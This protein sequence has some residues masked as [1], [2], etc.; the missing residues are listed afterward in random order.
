MPFDKDYVRLVLNENFEDAKALFLTPLMAI[1][2]AHLAM[3]AEQ[4]I[5][6]IEAARA[7]RGALA[8]IDLTAVRPT[9]YDGAYEDLVFY[10]ERLERD[11]TRLAAAFACV[12]RNPLGACA[13]TGTGFPIDRQRTSDLLGFDGPTGN[14]YGSIAAADYLLESVAAANVLL[15]GLGRL[16]QDL[17]LWCTREFG[18]LRLPDSLVQCSSV[19]PQKRNPVALEHAR[20][21]ASQGLGQW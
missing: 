5:I 19:M 4:R 2:H 6:P 17:L 9:G 3:L 1:H 16:V 12:N 14:T 8:G 11:A 21:P 20:A 7:I 10:L 15:V 18:Y 13:I